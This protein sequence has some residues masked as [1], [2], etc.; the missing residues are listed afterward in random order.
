MGTKHTSSE[1]TPAALEHLAERIISHAERY[2]LIAQQVREANA[3]LIVVPY[4]SHIADGLEGIRKHVFQAEMALAKLLDCPP[5]H[6]DL[7]GADPAMAAEDPEPYITPVGKNAPIPTPT[8]KK[9]DTRPNSSTK[10]KA[11]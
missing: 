4:P 9:A 10:K 6:R 2:K 11:E 7:A 5:E 8:R 3:A 1:Y